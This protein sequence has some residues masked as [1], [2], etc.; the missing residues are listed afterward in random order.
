MNKRQQ[1]DPDFV[2]TTPEEKKRL[3]VADQELQQGIYFTEA[4]VWEEQDRK[5]IG[6]GRDCLVPEVRRKDE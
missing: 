3:R 5:G 4:E 1:W 2:K 6:R